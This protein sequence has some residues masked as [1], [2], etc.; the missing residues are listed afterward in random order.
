MHI[1]CDCAAMVPAHDITLRV[2]GAGWHSRRI[3]NPV[4]AT[5][6]LLLIYRVVYILNMRYGIAMKIVP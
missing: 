6:Q 2:A 3:P 5:L 1:L 4:R